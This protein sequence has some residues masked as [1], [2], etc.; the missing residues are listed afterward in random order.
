M[1]RKKPVITILIACLSMMLMLFMVQ[2]SAQEIG[3][4][5]KGAS[6]TEQGFQMD[7]AVQNE[8]TALLPA[9]Q[10]TGFDSLDE[11]VKITWAEVPGAAKYRVYY[12]GRNGWTSMDDTADTSFID[13]DVG[14]GHTY[15]Y[16]VQCVSSGHERDGYHRS[17]I[18]L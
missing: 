2:T 17:A 1:L 14:S 7:P 15:T 11:G 10:I 9:P 3:N 5:D 16:S 18:H 12:K 8:E 6:I 4:A 13:T